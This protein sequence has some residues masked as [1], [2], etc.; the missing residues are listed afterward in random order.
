MVDLTSRAVRHMY[1]SNPAS[2]CRLAFR[3]LHPG[4]DYGHHWSI[5]VLGDALGRCH[6]GETRR[7]IINM[8]PRSLK[9]VCTS[10][11]FPAWIL[12]V[13]PETKI[14][15][16]AG[17][18]GLADDHHA[19]TR[20]LMNHPRYRSLFPHVRF[21]ETSNCLRLPQGGLR[22]AFTVSVGAGLTGRG[23]ELII[24][25]DPQAASDVDDRK[26]VDGV[27]S[28]YDRSIYQRLDDKHDGVIIVAMQRLAHEDLTAH[29]LDQ[30]GWELLSLPA[31]ATK[32]ETFPALFGDRPVRRKGEALNPARENRNQ[33]REAMLRMG[34]QAFMAQYQQAPYP[35]GEGGGRHGCYTSL[36]AGVPWTPD[37]GTPTMFFGTVPQE[38]IMLHTVFGEGQY[39]WPSDMREMTPEEWR[40]CYGNRLIER[41]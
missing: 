18:R 14:M 15:C 5:D 33:L 24:I 4:I 13:R 11:A 27:K 1:Q 16:V 17:H 32:D 9:S 39:P 40:L 8:P 21:S 26:K 7:L 3:L 31:I 6:R 29:L 19:L 36:R 22:T 30:G 28:W 25:D 23:A 37:Q 12:G 41:N 35:P 2:F 20:K 34:A 38:R 10:V